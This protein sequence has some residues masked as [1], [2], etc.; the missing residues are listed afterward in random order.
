MWRSKILAHANKNTILDLHQVLIHQL[1]FKYWI[2]QSGP[3]I[4]NPMNVNEQKYTTKFGITN[5]IFPSKFLF[6]A[7]FA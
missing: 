1:L 3:K 2:P 5:L 4:Q 7:I 6:E